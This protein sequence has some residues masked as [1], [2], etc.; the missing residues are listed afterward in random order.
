MSSKISFSKTSMIVN[1]WKVRK[2]KGTNKV[3]LEAWLP[4]HYSTIGSH[5]GKTAINNNLTGFGHFSKMT[6]IITNANRDKH[7]I[8][9]VLSEDNKVYKLLYGNK[10]S[11]NNYAVQTD[12]FI[13]NILTSLPC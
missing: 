2:I 3:E 10:Y 1:N 11:N 13:D 7:Q 5:A 8:W 12:A 4:V 6:I 9:H